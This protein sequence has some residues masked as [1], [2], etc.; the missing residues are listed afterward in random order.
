[1][2]MDSCPLEE[3]K[4]TRGAGHGKNCRWKCCEGAAVVEIE[5]SNGKQTSGRFVLAAGNPLIVL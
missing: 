3:C 5:A 1:M 4:A 2:E